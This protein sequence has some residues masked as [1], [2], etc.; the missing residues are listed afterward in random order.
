MG[1]KSRQ[2]LDTKQIETFK[3]ML[4]FD[5]DWRFVQRFIKNKK[6]MKKMLFTRMLTLFF[7]LYLPMQSMAWGMLGHR[8]VGEIA[9]HYLSKKAKKSIAA[10][11]GNESVAMSSNWADFIKS[12]PAYNYLSN[13]HYVNIVSGKTEQE[14]MKW[15]EADTTTNAYTKIIFLSK[16]LKKKEVPQ[17]DKVLYLR[18]LIHL[19]G[20]VHQPLHV[21]RPEDLGG[22]KVRVLW[23]NEP[24]NLHQVWD[25]AL[26]SSQNLS[27]TEYTKAI[28]FVSKDQRK[29]W[30]T[31]QVSFWFYDS[32]M[33]AEKVY[34]DVKTPDEKLG[35][36]YIFKYKAI[37]EAQLLK[38]GVRLAGILNDI[39]E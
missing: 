7:M 27:Y 8:I 1:C 23:F 30:Q 13:W 20:D 36:N 10:I 11:L 12:D 22:N 19:V 29:T 25:D 24:K 32:Y 2:K 9:D 39:F 15:L 38:G 33:V 4:S 28:N 14:V 21:G 35:Y 18:M 34:G 31:Q 26:I 16:E 17:S 37:A 3:T 5:C 6:K